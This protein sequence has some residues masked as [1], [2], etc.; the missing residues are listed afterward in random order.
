MHEYT[1]TISYEDISMRYTPHVLK[2]DACDPL[3]ALH[4][5]LERVSLE[6]TTQIED[7]VING[8]MRGYI[9]D[10]VSTYSKPNVLAVKATITVTSNPFT[11]RPVDYSKG[12]Q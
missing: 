9:F 6:H 10:A 8:V 3:S 2:V 11:N 12:K 4:R 5:T 1:V 7:M